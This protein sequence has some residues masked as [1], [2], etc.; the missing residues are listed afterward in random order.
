MPRD[1]TDDDR[2]LTVVEREHV[3]EIPARP[4]PGRGLVGGG[5]AHR[6]KSC[7]RDNWQQRCLQQTDVVEQFPALTLEAT[8]ATSRHS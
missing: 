5:R 8:R 4:G 7:R 3:V 1:V 2:Q 6:A